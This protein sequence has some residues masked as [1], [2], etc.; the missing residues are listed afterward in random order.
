LEKIPALIVCDLKMPNKDGYEVCD[1]LKKD[2]R[3]SHIPIVLLTA[4]S[5]EESRIEGLRHGA[6]AYLAKPFNQEELFVRL[7][8]LH[9]LRLALQARY[10]SLE[11]IE[12]SQHC[13]D[14]AFILKVRS[15]V[16][17]HL[18]DD[19]FGVPELCKAIG[20]SRSQLHLKLKALTNRSTSHN[21][22]AIRLH[23]AKKLL[24]TSDL[25]V[26]QVAYEVGF[27]DP[28][29]FTRSF[30]EEFGVPPRV[31]KS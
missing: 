21:I 23:K 26:T 12:H 30:S 19:N 11:T 4:K 15:I 10:S 2:V 25:N 17:D 14:D 9:E 24:K 27:N 31:F 28:A 6:D 13:I 5:D 1:T 18:S 7:E 8:K 16:E 29:Y 20:M 3:T 22:R